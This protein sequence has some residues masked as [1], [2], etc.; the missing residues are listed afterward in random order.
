MS[1]RACEIVCNILETWSSVSTS[2]IAKIRE[3]VLTKKF[4][5]A[6]GLNDDGLV[7]LVGESFQEMRFLHI[8]LGITFDSTVADNEMWYISEWLKKK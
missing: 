3:I 7:A 4:N 1:A 2:D 5:G 6:A 8:K